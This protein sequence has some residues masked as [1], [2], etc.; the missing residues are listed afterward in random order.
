MFG[1]SIRGAHQ[2]G[3]KRDA[4]HEGRPS[5][6]HDIDKDIE[7]DQLGD[8]GK[9]PSGLNEK[10]SS[11][12][13]PKRMD[14]KSTKSCVP[15]EPKDLALQTRLL[16]VPVSFAFEVARGRPAPHPAADVVEDSLGSVVVADVTCCHVEKAIVWWEEKRRP[17]H[18]TNAERDRHQIAPSWIRQSVALKHPVEPC[19]KER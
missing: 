2:G 5:K 8:K 1:L 12:I 19:H 9:L 11:D 10:E 17:E 4:K 14:Q 18:H 6:R 3:D 7:E 16:K 13:A 15:Q